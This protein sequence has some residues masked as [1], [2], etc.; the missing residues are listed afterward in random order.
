MILRLSRAIWIFAL[1][2]PLLSGPAQAQPSS[3]QALLD[4]VGRASQ[5][6]RYSGVRKVQMKFGPDRVTHTEYIL[7][8]GKKTRI[9]FPDEGSFRGQIIVETEKERRHYFPEKN[10]VE[11]MPP[12]REENAARFGRFGRDGSQKPLLKLEDGEVIVGIDTKRV[13][14]FNK[15]GQA[16]M[17]L[18]ID[19]KTGLV[20]KRIFY[21]KQGT[22]QASA[23]FT[24]VDLTPQFRKSDFELNIRGAKI[25]TPRDR[26]AEL[27]SRGDYANVSLSPKDPFQLES[28]RI[29]RI[30][31]VPA[32]VQVYVKKDGRVSLIQLKAH[33]DPNRLKNFGRGERLGT[34]TWQRGGSSFVLVGDMSESRLRDLAQRLGG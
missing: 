20:L 9:W 7:R 8:D 2:V 5:K 1:G 31:N 34:Y 24:K 22:I 10:Q 3:A 12:R 4:L 18:W 23:E 19:P 16:F 13:A 21:D 32:L 27:V 28:A 30:E 29:Q 33:I 17:R 14:F 11:V 15:A 25:Y 26:L 6:L